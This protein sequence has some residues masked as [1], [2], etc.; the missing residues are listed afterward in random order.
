MALL[1]TKAQRTHCTRIWPRDTFKW[2]AATLGALAIV[3][4]TSAA[5]AGP[6]V[7]SFLRRVGIGN[8]EGYHAYECC[9]PPRLPAVVRVKPAVSALSTISGG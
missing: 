2:L 5:W 1:A 4:G 7:N 3:A 6:R 8:S 9:I